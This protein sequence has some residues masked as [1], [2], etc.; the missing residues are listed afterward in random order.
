MAIGVNLLRDSEFIDKT[1]E[2]FAATVAS[3]EA[4]SYD[5]EGVPSYATNVG[6]PVIVTFPTLAVG[7]TYTFSYL[8]HRGYASKTMSVTVGDST[9]T[10]ATVLSSEWQ[11]MSITFVATEQTT[12][13]TACISTTPS[14]TNWTCN[15]KHFKLE[16]GNTAT[17]WIPHPSE[18]GVSF[19][20]KYLSG[21]GLS[22]LM[23]KIKSWAVSTFAP[24]SHTHDYTKTRVKGNAET[25]YRTG[26]V[27]LT[28]AN[29]G[30]VAK[31]AEML[32]TN[33][34]R[35]S[36]MGGPYISKIDNAFYAAD[37]RWTVTAVKSASGGNNIIANMFNGDYESSYGPSNGATATIT[38]DFTGSGWS[39]GGV[40]CFPNYPYGNIILS[41][42]YTEIPANV[43][44]R[45]YC[46]FA[47]QG[48]GWHDLTFSPVADNT[49]NSC[50]YRARQSFYAIS[51][52][53]ITITARESGLTS[54]TQVEMHLDRPYSGRN[55]FLSKYAAETLYYN[56]T[57]PKFIGDLQGKADSLKDAGNNS[58]ITAQYSGSGITTASW[59]AAWNGYKIAAISAENA[60]TAL[61][62]GAIGKKASLAASD[63]P[64]HASTATTYGAASTSN[65]GHAKLS[66]ATDSSSESLAATPKAVKAAYDLANTANTAAGQALSAATGA[67]V[68]KVTYSVSGST[69]TCS[70]HVYSA[71]EEV[72]GNY[73][74]SCFAW[75]M[76]LNGGTSWTALGTGRT[77][78]VSAITAF[79]GNVKCD[80]T[81]A[82]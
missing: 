75:S 34:F 72:T 12:S 13:A 56:L 32:T 36:S 82:S 78:T 63:I 8:F 57:A 21:D 65:Y 10:L 2:T 70:A 24:L 61:G 43:T 67:L 41:F 27:N 19:M 33:P 48:V 14:T 64:A 25:S 73:A 69:T 55:P 3:K 49:A 80:F 18:G 42:Y 16:I 1:K 23:S 17:E 28:P 77:K 9:E 81:P 29:I 7:Q 35:P 40:E 58:A 22:H 50:V 39:Y 79:G 68:F 46:N 37:K 76:S 59:F 4:S 51:K 62:G 66:S 20:A 38:I 30:A 53:E 52:L 47:N 31:T 5:F 54:C 45:V 74:D 26:D 15:W 44:G 60:W 11:R 6:K 71:G